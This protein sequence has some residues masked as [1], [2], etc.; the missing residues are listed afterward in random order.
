[1]RVGTKGPKAFK[2]TKRNEYEKTYASRNIKKVAK[3]KN[4]RMETI[5]QKRVHEI[6]NIS[7][8][9]MYFCIVISVVITLIVFS[10]SSCLK[11]EILFTLQNWSNNQLDGKDGDGDGHTNL[12]LTSYITVETEE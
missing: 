11:F 5:K 12:L 4:P 3:M 6:V 7:V 1:M 2:K 10:L 8:H 9:I